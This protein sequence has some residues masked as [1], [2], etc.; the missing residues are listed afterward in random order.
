MCA[1]CAST[2]T[3]SNAEMQVQRAVTDSFKVEFFMSTVLRKSDLHKAGE[4]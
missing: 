4:L 3:K 1:S 2:V